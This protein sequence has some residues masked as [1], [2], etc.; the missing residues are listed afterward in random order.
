MLV[1]I[2]IYYLLSEFGAVCVSEVV[3]FFFLLVLRPTQDDI[4][5][6]AKKAL[7]SSDL[8]M[9]PSIA[10]GDPCFKDD[11]AIQILY[12]YLDVFGMPSL[13]HFLFCSTSA[14]EMFASLTPAPRSF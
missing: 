2:F 8:Y 10:C 7:F 14:W 5:T 6:T 13:K 3:F 1:Y 12:S 11:Y 4:F 9:S